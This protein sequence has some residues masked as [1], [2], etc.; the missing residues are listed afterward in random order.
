MIY[1]QGGMSTQFTG[2]DSWADGT[3]CVAF[4]Q[5]FQL[6]ATLYMERRNTGGSGTDNL[7]EYSNTGFRYF[8]GAD[9]GPGNVFYVA[10]GL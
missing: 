6:V 4:S 8:H 5:I 1:P 2:G 7:Y 3:F 9:S 10:F